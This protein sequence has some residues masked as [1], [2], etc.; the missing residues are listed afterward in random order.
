MFKRIALPVAALAAFAS[1]SSVQAADLG[2]AVLR[3]SE[4]VAPAY[5]PDMWSGAYVGGQI[6]LQTIHNSGSHS[7]ATNGPLAD[8]NGTLRY[9]FNYDYAKTGFSYGLHAGYQRL[10][11]SVLLG[12]EA[13]IEGPMNALS[14]S[15]YAGNPDFGAG[16]FYQQRIQSNWQTSIRARFGFV[17]HATLFYMT[18]GV[19]IANFKY[20]TVIDS[21]QGN[22]AQHVVKFNSTR[23]GWTVGAGFE[24]K[25]SYNWSVR[26]EYR[27]SNYGSRNCFSADA[28]SINANSS[29]IANKVESHAVR[30]GVSYLFGAPPVAAPIMARY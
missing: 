21:C 14:S 2:G 28:C 18:G 24:H 12:I 11:N 9:D 27:Y 19:A 13:D 1:F 23:I 3:G 25:L 6:G 22:G 17:H 16:N 5:A 7:N 20:C 30:V 10:F 29:D 8:G 26:M 4:V 15:W